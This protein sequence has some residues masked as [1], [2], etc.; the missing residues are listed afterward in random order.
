MEK[1]AQRREVMTQVAQWQMEVLGAQETAEVSAPFCSCLPGQP[2]NSH[3]LL[4]LRFSILIG[5]A[6]EGEAAW[7]GLGPVMS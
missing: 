5:G 3:I 4:G 2:I 7:E 1:Q 6:S